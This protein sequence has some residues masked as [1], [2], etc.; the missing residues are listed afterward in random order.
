MIDKDQAHNGASC[1][2]CCVHN[3]PASYQLS[4]LRK[5]GVICSRTRRER[6]NCLRVCQDLASEKS[7]NF[8]EHE[9]GYCVSTT[10]LSSWWYPACLVIASSR[11]PYRVSSNSVEKAW[12]LCMIFRLYSETSTPSQP[13]YQ[14]TKFASRLIQL[15][16]LL[17]AW[18]ICTHI[19][20][21]CV[22]VPSKVGF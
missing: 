8:A 14:D 18:A 20:L 12:I 5:N 15:V 7:K 10:H 22:H 16:E 17:C 4:H 19:G 9:P 6:S 21:L 13:N 1:P 11:E 3:R 2:L